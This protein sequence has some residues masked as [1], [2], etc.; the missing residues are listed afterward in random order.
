MVVTV[1]LEDGGEGTSYAV[2][3][4][5]RA[6]RAYYELTGRRKRGLVLR[7][8]GQPISEQYPVPNPEA[9]ELRPGEV[10]SEAQD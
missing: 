8:D 2:P 6:I 4:A 1:F 7:E 5:D 9:T 3:V 10:I